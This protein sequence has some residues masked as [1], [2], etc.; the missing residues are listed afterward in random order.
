MTNA[1]TL[2]PDLTYLA[3]VKVSGRT[4]LTTLNFFLV[5]CL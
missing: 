5:T 2:L 4:V 3:W 1:G